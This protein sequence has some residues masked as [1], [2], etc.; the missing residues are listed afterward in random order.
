MTIAV[1][2]VIYR[3]LTFQNPLGV[4]SRCNQVGKK[5]VF[6]LFEMQTFGICGVFATTNSVSFDRK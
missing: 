3:F 4:Y 5:E 6:D 2:Y 1:L